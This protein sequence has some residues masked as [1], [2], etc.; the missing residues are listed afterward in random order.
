M[1]ED[2]IK[3]SGTVTGKEEPGNIKKYALYCR[4]STTDQTT[5]N[6]KLRLVEWANRNGYAYDVFTETE[7]T[8]KTRPVKQE[9]MMK[10]RNGV[11]SGVAVYKLCRWARSSAELIMDVSELV[12]KGIAFISLSDNFDFGT[13]SGKL[14]FQILS[15]FAE[16][17]RELIRERTI[18]GLRRAK[19]QGKNPGR[20]YGSRD[21]TPRKR[22]GYI[23]HHAKKRQQEAKTQ[24]IYTAV[25]KYIH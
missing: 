20:P 4:V 6:Q 14:H 3:N 16:F 15:A 5:D 24:G 12:K 1:S 21:K 19:Q 11:Y 23:L 18:E 9:L 22:S 13:A 25:E 8:R 10:L 7:S 17:E 2:E